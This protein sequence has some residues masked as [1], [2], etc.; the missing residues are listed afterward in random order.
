MTTTTTTTAM[1]R[2]ILAST[3]AFLKAA[4]EALLQF[5][6]SSDG[7]APDTS[8]GW[9]AEAVKRWALTWQGP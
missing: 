5:V 1:S 6:S 8:D 9:R 2:L 3:T 4:R 7:Q